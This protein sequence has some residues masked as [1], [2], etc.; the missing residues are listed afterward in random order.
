[1]AMKWVLGILFT[2]GGKGSSPS[3]R[4]SQGSQGSGSLEEKEVVEA[5]DSREKTGLGRPGEALSGEKYSP[6]VSPQD[7]V[8][9]SWQ[10]GRPG[11]LLAGCLLGRLVA[12][13]PVLGNLARVSG[14][15]SLRGCLWPPLGGGTLVLVATSERQYS[16][17][18]GAA[19]TAQVCR[20]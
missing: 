9:Y 3:I 4:P 14:S 6:K 8:F 20:S 11:P 17:L 2:E 12:W 7:F 5:T 13:G 15:R 19:G 1:M 16:I 10:W 18:A